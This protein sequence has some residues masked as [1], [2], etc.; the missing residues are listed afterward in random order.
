VALWIALGLGH[1]AATVAPVPALLEAPAR[2]LALGLGALALALGALGGRGP[3]AARPTGWRRLLARAEPGLG[4]TA[5]FLSG[6]ALAGEADLAARPLPVHPAGADVVVEGKVLDTTAIDASPG[7]VLLQVRSVRVGETESPCRA[8]VT[9]RWRDDALPPRWMLP[10]LWL[11]CSGRYRPP[12]DA[13]NPGGGAP[14]RWLERSGIAGAIAVDPLSISAPPDPPERGASFGAVLRDRLAR[15]LGASLSPPV[16]ALA[17]GMLL[18]DRSGI[19]P[20]VERSFRAGGTIHILSIS[21]LHVCIVAGFLAVVAAMF[22]L[23]AGPAA[24]LELVALWGY[25]ALVGAPASAARSAIL[26]TAIRS[27]RLLGQ[28]VR[29]F[30]AWGLAGLLLHLLDPGSVSDPGFQLSFLAVLGLG[31]TGSLSRLPF[32]ARRAGSGV[33]GR[34]ERWFAGAWSLFVQSAGATVG[35]TGL[36]ARLFGAVPFV[37]LALNL[38]VIP[39]CTLFM[40]EAILLL[41]LAATPLAALAAAAAGAVDASGLLLL[42]LNARV[43]SLA[44]PWIVPRLPSELAVIGA[45]I[46]LVASWAR[47]EAARCGQV[48]RA[49]AARWTLA[50]L[51]LAIAVPFLPERPAPPSAD[52]VVL[53]LDVGQGDA[54][55]VGLPGGRSVLIDAGPADENRDSGERVVEPA[56]RAEGRGPLDAA[57]L[58]HAHL[59][60]FGGFP[61]LASRGWFVRW[62]ENGSDPRGSWRRTI[63]SALR[64]GHG[65]RIEIAGDTLLGISNAESI[66]IFRGFDGT[67]ENDRSIAALVGHGEGSILFAG[68][69]ETAGEAAL[70]PR[71]VSVGVLKAPHHGSK[72]SSGAQWVARLRPRVVL[73]SCGE[74]NR[75]GHPDSTVLDRYRRAGSTVWRTDQEGAIRVT[76]RPRGAWVSTRRHPAPVFVAWSRGAP[77]TPSTEPP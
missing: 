38:A 47:A 40:A 2:S 70:L 34:I 32:A 39:L 64:A 52:A 63:A 48:A 51:T 67:G 26:W 24:G 75:F 11:R 23:P 29:P 74:G 45:A 73:I 62:A 15:V 53:S 6:A 72:T 8:T 69:L 37:G 21:G 57:I 35:T 9:L 56:L 16:A 14:G 77:A 18:G 68:D 42:T 3:G 61:W 36:Q 76:L 1:L 20:V 50:A 66:R 19:D 46:A 33:R 5:L 12:E 41:A 58:S 60:H 49:S 43:A 25:V 71:L 13:R 55:W 10:G 22:R 27:G 4:W 17:R 59:D 65:A 44:A 54:T 28:S 30:T 31:G 7:S